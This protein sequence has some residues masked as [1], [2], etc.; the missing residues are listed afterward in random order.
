MTE[1]ITKPI[2]TLSPKQM[3]NVNH[4]IFRR[5]AFCFSD[6]DTFVFYGMN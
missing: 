1:E 3:L 6:S 2:P 4:S 5:R